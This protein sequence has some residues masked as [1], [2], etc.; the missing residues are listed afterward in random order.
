MVSLFLLREEDCQFP[1]PPHPPP[2][3]A[4]IPANPLPPTLC[5][6]EAEV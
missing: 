1:P 6:V 3:R 4:V 5:K 2:S